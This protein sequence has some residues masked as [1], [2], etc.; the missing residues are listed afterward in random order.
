MTRERTARL[1]AAI[2][3]RLVPP[4]DP[5]VGDLLEEFAAGRSRGWLWTQVVMAV[6]VAP[7]RGPTRLDLSDADGATFG[8][9]ELER[10][11]ARRA[12]NISG[13]PVSGIGG[14]GLV[15]MAVLVSVTSPAA[16]WMAAIGPAAGVVLGITLVLARRRHPVTSTPDALIRPSSG[17]RAADPR[18]R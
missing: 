18:G 17:A 11:C 4:N 5:L 12:V 3:D 2:L 8:T 15:A 13:S 1:A 16:W 9:T 7:G 10:G 14:L 6:A